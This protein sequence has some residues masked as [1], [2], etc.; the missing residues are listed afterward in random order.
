MN[1]KLSQLMLGS[2]LLWFFVSA[3]LGVE[4]QAQP[5]GVR[6]PVLRDVGIDQLLNNPVPLDLDFVDETGRPVKLR[7]YFTDKPVLLTLVYYDCPQLCNQ[8]LTGAVGALKTLPMVPGKDFIWLTVSFDHREQPELAAAKKDNYVKQLGK[9]EAAKGWHFLTGSEAA[10]KELTHA[11]GFRFL[12]DPAKKQ[13]AH[14]SGIMVLTPDGKVSRYFYG[15]EYAPRDLRLG[16]VDAGQGRIGSL[17]DQ[18]IMYCY[19]Y[20]PTTGTYGLQVMRVLRIFAVLTLLTL[21]VL[22]IFLRYKAK[23]KEAQ[24]AEAHAAHNHAARPLQ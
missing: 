4:V 2:L 11:V 16:F 9:P 23:Q 19:L 22:F 3:A 20:D 15:I 14:A 5:A 12:W 24:W 1:K 6:P 8:V 13:Y 7:E 21:V 18:I 10:V 17:A